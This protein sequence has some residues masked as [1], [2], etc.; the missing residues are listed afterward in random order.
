MDKVRYDKMTDVL[1]Q[2]ELHVILQLA[3]DVPRRTQKDALG[4][5]DSGLVF[6]VEISPGA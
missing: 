6:L 3:M 4:S 5:G 1:P 2:R